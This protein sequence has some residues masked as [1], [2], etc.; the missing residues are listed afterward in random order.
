M[1]VLVIYFFTSEGKQNL[2]IFIST[3]KHMR[4][5]PSCIVLI[6]QQN[7]IFIPEIEYD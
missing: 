6:I 3:T 7:F 4:L 1:S 5:C 2:A